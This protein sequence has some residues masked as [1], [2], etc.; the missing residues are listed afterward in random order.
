MSPVDRVSETGQPSAGTTNPLREQYVAELF[1][2]KYDFHQGTPGERPGPTERTGDRTQP[3]NPYDYHQGPSDRVGPP[4]PERT[5]DRTKFEMVRNAKGEVDAIKFGD[6]TTLQRTGPKEW[7]ATRDGQPLSAQDLQAFAGANAL[8]FPLCAKDGKILGNITQKDANGD[9][10]YDARNTD[11]NIYV[12]RKPDGSKDLR[13]YNDYSRT[14]I[15][16][17][18]REQDKDYWDGYQWRHGTAE[19]LPSGQTQITFNQNERQPAGAKA[20]PKSVVRDGGT[21]SLTVQHND[22][23]VMHANWREQKLITRNAGRP[24]DVKYYDGENWRHGRELVLPGGGS[25]NMRKVEFTDGTGPQSV[26]VDTTSGDIKDKQGR[27]SEPTQEEREQKRLRD[28]QERLRREETERRRAAPRPTP[29]YVNPT[30]YIQ[31]YCPP[32]GGRRG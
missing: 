4:A 8:G 3:G 10:Q 23:L 31:P 18:G 5:S 17:D 14:K 19:K 28:E 22:Q 26:T 30:P 7:Q 9:V 24:E 25:A 32:N 21:D 27:M 20:W 29:Q 12:T 16:A 11:L 13:N 1:S 15:G 6:G 2:G